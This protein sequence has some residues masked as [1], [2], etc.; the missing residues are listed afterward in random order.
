[1]TNGLSRQRLLFISRNFPPL[2]GGM[3]RLNHHAYLALRANY[4]VDVCGPAGAS[5]FVVA[6]D[7]CREIPLTPL[8]QYLARCQWQAWRMA[9]RYRSTVVYSGSGL[10]APA[11]LMAGRSV[12]AR[13]VSFLHGLDIVA[14]QPIYRGL[15]LPAIRRCDRL[16]VNSRHTA[17]LAIAAGVPERRIA[18]V[19]P[20]VDIPDW[21]QRAPA[22]AAF[23]Q[24]FALGDHPVLLAAGRLTARK[25]VA[26]FIRHA[27]P[28]IIEQIPRTILLIIGSEPKQALKHRAGVTAEI[29]AAIQ[30]TGLENHVK[31]LGRVDDTT[32]TLAYFAADLH[33]FPVLDLPGD[34]EGFGMVA[35]E[36]AA[37]GLPTVAFGVGGVGDAVADGLSGWL[38]Q[39]ADYSAMSS[40]IVAALRDET[41]LAT[42]QG[43]SCRTHASGFTWDIFGTRLLEAIAG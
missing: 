4:G 6:G 7:N 37:H 29:L 40:R 39:P 41:R 23:R 27:L 3:E 22:R 5:N 2:T 35:I 34:V 12:G 26:P 14:D 20:G 38:V 19:H 1:M 30:D 24:R 10:T 15:F 9:R 28:R 17:N 16:L 13:I 21:N 18:I 8:S 31:L 25:G 33:V 32:L 42:Q 36:A 11:A 43:N